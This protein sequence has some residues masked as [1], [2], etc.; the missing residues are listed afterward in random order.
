MDTNRSDQTTD[1]IMSPEQSSP[2]ANGLS[3]PKSPS[4]DQQ[5]ELREG[6][7]QLRLEIERLRDQQKAFQRDPQPNEPRSAMTPKTRKM[8]I[9]IRKTSRPI[10]V[11]LAALSG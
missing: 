4:P 6:I 1:K 11:C 5:N 9:P 3:Y 7:N 2:N 8:T 10:G